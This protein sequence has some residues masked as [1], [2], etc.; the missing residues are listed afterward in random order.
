VA[1]KV[2]G[3]DQGRN[4]RLVVTDLEQA[5]TTVLSQHISWARGPA[6]NESKDHQRSVP[7]DRPSCHR[8]AANQGRGFWHAAASVWLET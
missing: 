4:T 1:I 5:R 7:S 6:A 3:S 8:F 2:E